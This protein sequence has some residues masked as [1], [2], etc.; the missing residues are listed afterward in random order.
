MDI[1]STFVDTSVPVEDQAIPG[2]D[3]LPVTGSVIMTD[4]VTSATVSVTI[5]HV[6]HT[7]IL[8]HNPYCASLVTLNQYVPSAY[9]IVT[10]FMA[11]VGQ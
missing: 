8:P 6:S 3:F 1:C 9:M 10:W 2:I 5:L 11:I 7:E 4:N